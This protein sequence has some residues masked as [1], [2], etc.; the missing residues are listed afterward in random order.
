MIQILCLIL[1]NQEIRLAITLVCRTGHCWFARNLRVGDFAQPR[2]L[3]VKQITNHA[4]ALS[5]A[6]QCS[7]WMH[8]WSERGNPSARGLVGWAKPLA[9]FEHIQANYRPLPMHPEG[10]V[11]WC[12]S[13]TAT[14][15][16]GLVCELINPNKVHAYTRLPAGSCT[17]PGSQTWP[18]C[19]N[20]H[21]LCLLLVD[22]VLYIKKVHMWLSNHLIMLIYWNY[23]VCSLSPPLAAWVGAVAPT[24]A[25]QVRFSTW[26]PLTRP[27][28]LC[29]S[30]KK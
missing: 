28:G 8:Q 4:S 6:H 20:F 19:C 3:L 14:P 16:R 30:P 18:L 26:S 5:N 12:P 7:T 9:R 25:T 11:G 29:L 10:L 24:Q 22:E 21:H 17:G 23:K 1:A 15:L 13:P 2:A 27:Y